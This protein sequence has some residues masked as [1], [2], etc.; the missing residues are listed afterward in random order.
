MPGQNDDIDK[1]GT[2]RLGAYPCIL[3]ENS[4]INKVLWN[5]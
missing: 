1:G 3:K 5:K 2:L 4:M